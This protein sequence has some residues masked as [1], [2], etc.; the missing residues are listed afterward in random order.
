M[1]IIGFKNE[2]KTKGFKEHFSYEKSHE[3]HWQTNGFKSHES[4]C[5]V[6]HY[7][8][9]KTW[10]NGFW[11]GGLIRTWLSMEYRY[12]YRYTLSICVSLHEILHSINMETH[13]KTVEWT[14][15]HRI[16]MDF[17]IS[18]W[19]ADVLHTAVSIFFKATM[20][21]PSQVPQRRQ[22]GRHGWEIPT[23]TLW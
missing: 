9:V 23:I 5:L 21:R 17:S 11:P 20:R 19:H 6:A 1:L 3:F 12:I 14:M 15:K 16:S 10:T 22:L 4:H 13:M 8:G 18:F 7:L 2:W